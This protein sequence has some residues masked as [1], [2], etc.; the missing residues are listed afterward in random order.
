LPLVVRGTPKGISARQTGIGIPVIVSPTVIV[1]AG[2]E[3]RNLPPDLVFVLSDT[4]GR[5]LL[6]QIVQGKTFRVF[7]KI[8]RAQLI[9]QIKGFA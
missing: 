4:M 6:S 2:K 5:V 1:V 9:L 7:Q 8:I 3:P